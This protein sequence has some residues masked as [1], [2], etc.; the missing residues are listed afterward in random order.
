MRGMGALSS[1][2]GQSVCSLLRGT[3]GIWQQLPGP[4]L[5]RE[6]REKAGC[7]KFY[8]QGWTF[9]TYLSHCA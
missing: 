3:R 4:F 5:G 1:R 6:E 2:G 8:L 9:E 7:E